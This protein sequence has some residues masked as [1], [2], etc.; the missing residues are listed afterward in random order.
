MIDAID[1]R[2]D[3]LAATPIRV[4]VAAS[5]LF[6]AAMLM[7]LPQLRPPLFDPSEQIEKETRLTVRLAPPFS[8]PPEILPPP[9]PAPR[10]R[11]RTPPRVIALERPAP[12]ISSPPPA[13]PATTPAPAATAG[14]LLAYV[15]ARRRERADPVA[16]EAPSPRVENDSSRANRAA[17]ANL[18]TQRQITFGY[19]PS[20]S[21]GVFTIERL[22]YDYAEFTFVGWQP[23]MRRRV[24]QLIEVERG[25]NSDIRIAVVRKMISIIRAYEPVEFNWDSRYLGR[26]VTLSARMRDNAGLEEFMM[27]EFFAVRP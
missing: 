14:D 21:G 8:A 4:A 27:R 12:G 22:G 17:A 7:E 23:D 13:P 19:D 10:V 1:R 25:G 20:R 9:A 26:S 16:P 18:A 2:R 11:P 15:E 3:P 5:V 24:K 6:H